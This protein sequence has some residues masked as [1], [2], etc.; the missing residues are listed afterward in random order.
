MCKVT[1]F[2]SGRKKRYWRLRELSMILDK[3]DMAKT[4]QR[5]YA[6]RRNNAVIVTSRKGYTVRPRAEDYVY[7]MNL[8]GQFALGAITNTAPV[9]HKGI[10][11]AKDDLRQICK[12][13]AEQINL[14]FNAITNA[15]PLIEQK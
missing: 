13:K 5:I 10:K 14:Q 6:A 4:A 2:M 1:V 12:E 15:Q 8:M 7:H 9:M 3:G 11:I